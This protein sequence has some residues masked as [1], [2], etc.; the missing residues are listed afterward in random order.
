MLSLVALAAT[1]VLLVVGAIVSATGAGLACPDWPLCHGRLIPP[2]DRLVLIEYGHRLLASAV[3]LLVLWLAVLAWMHSR[4]P[5]G[6][7]RR[8][9][10][11]LALLG[12][13]VGLGGATVLSSLTPV[14]VGVHLGTAMAFTGLLAAFATHAH[15]AGHP[16]AASAGGPGLSRLA[17]VAVAL[18]YVQ[19]LTGGFTSAFGAGLACGGLPLCHG[20][21]VPAGP[22][23]AVLHAVHR[24]LGL[25]VVAVVLVL[26]ARGR[27]SPEAPVRRG[28]LAA[29]VLALV[30]VGL[31]VLNVTTR[32]ALEV[33][34]AHLG[35]AA[36][37]L[38]VLVALATWLRAPGDAR[39]SAAQPSDGRALA[40]A[41]G[42]RSAAPVSGHGVARLVADYLALTKPR[43]VVLLLL[44]TLTTMV[45][46]DGGRPGAALVALTLL[47]GALAAG[48]ANA[49][50]CYCDRDIDALMRRTRGRPLPAGRVA[51]RSALA[52]GMALAVA[53][54]LVLGLGVN[55]LSAILA[56]GGIVFY[57]GVYTLWL[58]RSTPQNIVI[59][60]A[61]G[62]IP[63]LVGWA[64]VT[65][66]VALP[67]VVLFAIV[68]LWTPPHFWALAL[69][70]QDEYRAAGVPMLPVVAGP[71]ETL[72][73]M[74]RYTLALV[75]AT[76]V[77]AGLGVLGR[78]YLVAAVV[79]A[80]PFVVLVARLARR[81]TPQQ[82]WV[83]FEYSVVYL[84]LLFAAMAVDRLVG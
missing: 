35:G 64:A 74:V 76:L 69:H 23:P 50:N 16:R 33:R 65:N 5:G 70:R 59:G 28:V 1:W 57:V 77:L 22:P 30:Q 52:F 25:A 10:G 24:L 32:L 78:L 61:A 34:V 75:A 4:G 15:R 41:S 63:P 21:V 26:A 62:A 45:V 13:Q 55:W 19:I 47:G 66:Q 43:I 73:Q 81:P 83:V 79:L 42:S 48:S 12:L 18:T 71:Q 17:A 31:G 38:A 8:A 37:L 36:A 44:T 3:G 53:A 29:A 60:G 9:V 39:V 51:P 40:P 56:A 27:A 2:L 54:V 14:V 49:I 46:A 82:A 7:A 20:A 72:R 67:A 84:G 11:L 58:K 80:V 68:F 6:L